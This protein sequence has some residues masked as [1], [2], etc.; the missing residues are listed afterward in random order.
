MTIIQLFGRQHQ[1]TTEQTERTF[2]EKVLPEYRQALREID[3]NLKDTYLKLQAGTKPED[4][5][6]EVL[7]Y[8]RYRSLMEST[9]SAYNTA[10]KRAGL[11]LKA[12][13]EAN[14]ANSFYMRQYGYQWV[15]PQYLK[16]VS[17][18]PQALIDLAVLGTPEVWSEIAQRERD[19][20][21]AIYG[22]T[23]AYTPQYGT[24]S[25]ILNADATRQLQA[26]NNAITQG[27]IQGQSY[28]NVAKR[29][30]NA[31][32][33]TA[34][35]AL[36]IARTEGNR[37][38]NAGNFAT[39]QAAKEQGAR[40]VRQWDATLDGRT[41]EDHARLDG[42]QEDENGYF[43]IDGMKAQYPSHFGV[44]RMDIN[45]RCGI[46]DTIDRVSPEARTGRNP[47]TGNRNETISFKSFDEW[48]KENNLAY[49]NGIL[50]PST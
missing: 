45:C 17:Y 23:D 16:T 4:Y 37:L 3:E 22:T 50:R 24:L 15:V 39:S 7:K 33:T 8:G 12:S 5:F 19:R 20:I 42:K 28:T 14:F 6:N 30:R 10:A 36:R 49:K 9:A 34:S 27:F 32:N 1:L 47:F 31:F 43:T 13:S 21:T 29:V 35:N 40:I 41:R 38:S 46:L 25:Q 11:Y 44:A 48:A 26:V 18:L 2:R